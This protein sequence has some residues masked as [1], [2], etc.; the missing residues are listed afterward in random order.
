M[1]RL[2]KPLGPDGYQVVRSNDAWPDHVARYLTTGAMLSWL[3]PESVADPACGD[4]S[5][6][7]TAN[8]IRKIEQL[9]LGDI[10]SPQ[11]VELQQDRS[12]WSN[13]VEWFTG[14]AVAF[15]DKIVHVDAIVLT[16]ILEHLEDPAALVRAARAKATY[17]IASSPINET[18]G[19]GN[20]EHVWSF[21]VPS[22]RQ[23]LEGAGWIPVAY[24]EL[25]FYPPFYD[26][27]LWVCR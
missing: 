1:K 15:L 16:E 24:Q 10:S 18:E 17:L 5:I 4:G 19:Q 8:S 11:I 20:H 27:Q 26:F 7:K 2:H 13:R 14:D 12:L 6:V 23:L 21:S 25:R 3:R 9:Y 22:Y